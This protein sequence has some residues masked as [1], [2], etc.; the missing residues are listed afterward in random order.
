MTETK[1]LKRKKPRFIVKES[2]NYARIKVR[3]RNPR[4]RH[5]KVRQRHCGRPAL[6]TPGYGSALA[7]RN[8]HPCGLEQ[9]NIHNLH[10]LNKLNP[11]TDGAIIAAGV[12][13]KNRLKLLQA[14][15][16]KKI[17]VLNFRNIEERIN[18]INTNFAQ[19]KK[20]KAEKLKEKDKKKEEKKKKAE[21]KKKKEEEKK[22]EAT[23]E[24]NSGEQTAT[25]E[26]QKAEQKE[27]EKTIIK[28]Q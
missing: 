23:A 17:T 8:K 7:I 3:W 24:E 19:R 11:K 9:I 22:Q 26:K 12:S 16:E 21:E 18:T 28:R 15:K 10:D 2:W 14:A 4:G 1:S 25:E 13:N 5:S 27:I 6:P 20:H